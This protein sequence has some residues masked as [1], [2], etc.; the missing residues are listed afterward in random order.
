MKIT[1][2]KIFVKQK[3]EMMEVFS[4]FET[5][6]KYQVL[7]ENGTDLFYAFEESNFFLRQFM[8]QNRKLKINIIDKSQKKHMVIERPWFFFKPSHT[9]R[10]GTGKII[11]YINGKFGF[12]KKRFVVLDENQNGVFEIVAGLFSPWTF[13][14]MKQGSQK[15]VISKK[16]SGIGKE[17]FTDADNFLIDFD[18]ITT[19]KEKN[20][21]LAAAFAIDL[22]YFEKDSHASTPEFE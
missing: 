14:V 19:E 8:S 6:N 16:W 10:D 11:G 18:Q 4:S 20:L 5:K 7:D 9:I 22:R 13:K 15:G 1:Q 2:N 17:M 12:F 3:V 21:M